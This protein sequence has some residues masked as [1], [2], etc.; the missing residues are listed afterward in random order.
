MPIRNVD[1]LEHNHAM[2][3]YH[4]TLC[5]QTG[6]PAGCQQMAGGCAPS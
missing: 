1:D 5:G 2:C 3:N 4:A 6:D